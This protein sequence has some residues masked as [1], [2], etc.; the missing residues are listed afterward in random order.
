[1]PRLQ[2]NLRSTSGVRTLSGA[3][4]LRR[5]AAGTIRS[6]IGGD[7]A[8][9]I[10]VSQFDSPVGDQGLFGPDSIAWKVGSDAAMLIGG[11]R[12]LL[13]QTVH[14]LA[15]AGVA[16]HSS[17]RADPWGRLQRTAMYVSTT[18]FGSTAAAEEMIDRVTAVHRSVRGIA[19]DGRRY[20]ALDPELLCWVHV[21]EVDSFAAAVRAY[22]TVSLSECEVDQ[23]LGEMALVGGLMGA[24]GI[25]RN[26]EELAA[27]YA[28]LAPELRGSSQAREAVRFLLWPPVPARL[29]PA[30]VCIVAAAVAILPT[31]MKRHLWL[32][33]VP[34]VERSVVEPAGKLLSRTLG[35]VLGDSPLVT[36]A[37]LRVSEQLG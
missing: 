33:E 9:P 34:L 29:R 3:E 18:T 2:A 25:P 32:P 11:V 20:S 27:Y 17:Y 6:L 5:R 28:R 31:D 19:P 37:R 13:M 4:F 15:M 35:W 10:D 36:A 1:M 16:E 14:P 7:G 22:G 21:T 26:N 12:A 24:E 8:A 23:Y 30:Y